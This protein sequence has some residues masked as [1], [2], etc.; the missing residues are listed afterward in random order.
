MKKILLVL[1]LIALAAP[2]AMADESA[3]E[4]FEQC[5]NWARRYCTDPAHAAAVDAKLLELKQ[6][7]V[8]KS[9]EELKKLS[10]VEAK[11]LCEKHG[12]PLAPSHTL[13]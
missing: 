11:A 9:A 12:V 6:K 2:A 3:L 7:G 10:F 5:N 1:G 13:F 8:E 4:T